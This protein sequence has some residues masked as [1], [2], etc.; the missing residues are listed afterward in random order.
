MIYLFQGCGTVLGA[1]FRLCGLGC[2]A[3]DQCCKTLSQGTQDCCKAVSD[4]WAPIASNPLGGYVLSTFAS[5][6]AV[7]VLSAMSISTIKC[8][9]P[10]TFAMVNCG[11]AV[12]HAAF[13][14]YIQ[15]RLVSE[16]GV[17]GRENMTHAEIAS[18]AKH[19]MLYDIFFCL[20]L[21][22]FVGSFFYNIYGISSLSKCDGTG[23]AWSAS[24]MMTFFIWAASCYFVCWI[25]GH[26][27]FAK[28]AQVSK[29]VKGI[30]PPQVMGTATRE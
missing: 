1:P 30:A 4:C 25:C 6:L 14:Y 26:C 13:A 8:D 29:S 17:E 27:C 24:A 22:V 15:R 5:M 3:F 28:A 18:K 12:V 16:I 7:L 2:K 20:Y 11:L 23:P 21:P 10:K 19:V 9:E